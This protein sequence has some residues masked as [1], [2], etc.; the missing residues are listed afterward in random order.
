[1]NFEFTFQN[2]TEKIPK[3][4]GNVYCLKKAIE[5]ETS[6]KIRDF[7]IYYQDEGDKILL[8]SD[9]DFLTLEN[10]QTPINGQYRVNVE[11]RDYLFKGKQRN[12]NIL[13]KC[14]TNDLIEKRR[15]ERVR[16]N[17]TDFKT[18]SD[19]LRKKKVSNKRILKILRKV[20]INLGLNYRLD[21]KKLA[22]EYPDKS[23][24]I[25]LDTILNDFSD[26]DDV[27]NFTTSHLNREFKNTRSFENS[28]KSEVVLTLERKIS[29][30]SD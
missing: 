20:K 4:K 2:K 29:K 11:K 7:F 19:Y 1:M 17:R 13:V 5:F 21:L 24:E 9:E 22:Y 15:Q 30:S 12:W 26:H 10:T 16:L 23:I 14:F 18:I 8:I 3:A 28:N 6:L 27:E 25:S